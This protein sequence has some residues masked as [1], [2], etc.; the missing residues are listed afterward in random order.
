MKKIIILLML[1]TTVYG[2]NKYEVI[3]KRN[4]FSLVGEELPRVEAV[5]PPKQPPIKLYLT[6]IMKYQGLTNVF[7]YSKDLPKRFLTLNRK[8]PSDNGIELLSVKGSQVKVMNQG[9]LENLSFETHRVPTVF[10]PAPV[11]NR[12]TVIKKDKGSKSTKASPSV[13]AASVVKVPSRRPKVD[14]RIIEKS[15]EYLNKVEDK[16]KREYL[17]E[18]L[19]KLQS[20]QNNLDRKIDVNERRR[21]YDERKRDK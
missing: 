20:G 19:E 8:R 17:L 13:P 14:P 2:Q 6:G 10:G 4:A 12:P 21:Q 11:F 3:N 16:E 1:V 7:L 18:R 15:L 5:L 9:V